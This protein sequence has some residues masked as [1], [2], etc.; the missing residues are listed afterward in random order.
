MKIL[1]IGATGLIGSRVTRQLQNLGHEVIPGS[2]RAGIDIISGEGLE[3]AMSGTA[4]VIDLSNSAAPDEETAT[5]FFNTAGQNLA[6]AAK[7]A[8]IQHHIVLSIVGVDSALHIGY[9]RAKKAQE[10]YVRS[11]GIPYTIL[12][13]TQF[14]EHITT[15]MEVQAT[16]NDIH[17]STL[18]YQPVAAADVVNTICRIAL[19][20]AINGTIEIAG[21]ERKLMNEFVS[22]YID[23]RRLDKRVIP[24]NENQYMFYHL[25]KSALVPAG[26]FIKGPTLFED[27][28]SD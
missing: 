1:V 14:H 9:L 17:V 5:R 4:I 11:S 6:K 8:G 13:A 18:D 10:T 25:P 19:E 12:R 15:I 21:P 26:R 3:A 22:S 27:W 23:I 2:R 28:A 7:K 16:G 20:P 24:N